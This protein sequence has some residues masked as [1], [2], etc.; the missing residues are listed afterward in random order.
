MLLNLFL[1][2]VASVDIWRCIRHIGDEVF[3]QFL[4]A[5]STKDC[6]RKRDEELEFHAQFLLVKFNHE[7]GSIRR[8]AD[9]YLSQLVDR[10][11]M[12]KR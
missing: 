3:R 5:I 7:N 10:Y 2:F 9:R 11:A 1:F 12:F 8:V 4:E 6:N